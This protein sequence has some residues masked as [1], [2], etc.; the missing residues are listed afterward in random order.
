MALDGVLKLEHM[1]VEVA[2]VESKVSGLVLQIC[3]LNLQL[4]LV[5]LVGKLAVPEVHVL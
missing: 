4:V 3:D 1:A 2:V 5:L